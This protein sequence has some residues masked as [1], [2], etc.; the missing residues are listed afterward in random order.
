MTRPILYVA[1]PYG[2]P[3]PTIR[4]WHT[5]RAALLGKLA[6]A[7]GYNPI[8]PHLQI[9]AGV[10]G[11]DSDPE[12]RAAG[13][14]ATLD[15]CRAVVAGGGAVW[16]LTRDDGMFS[17]GTRAEWMI[18]EGLQ[19][20]PRVGAWNTWRGWTDEYAPYLIPEWDRLAV[21]PDRVGEWEIG[22]A[23]SFRWYAGAPN[24][25]DACAAMVLFEGWLAY[26]VDHVEFASGPETGA[27]GRAAA[28][29]ALRA[30]GVLT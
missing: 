2:D 30:M 22:E 24:V 1:A 6:F 20:A 18:A 3:S 25:D 7:C 11:D 8:V 12:Q 21:R 27:A 17:D 15:V 16:A 10:Y 28:D 13:M 26:T 14:A 4:A 9:A 29:A 5:A 23:H 19:S